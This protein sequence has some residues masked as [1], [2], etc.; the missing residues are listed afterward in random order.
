MNVF[1]FTWRVLL[2]KKNGSFPP[3]TAAI[4]NSVALNRCLLALVVLLSIAIFSFIVFCN[5]KGNLSVC[6]FLWLVRRPH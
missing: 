3:D 6:L 1:G 2:M 4:L 5:K